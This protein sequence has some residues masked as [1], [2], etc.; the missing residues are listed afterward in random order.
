MGPSLARRLRR[1][2]DLSG[3]RRRIFAVSRFS[4]P[5]LAE[6]LAAA[7]IDVVRADLLERAQVDALPD[8]AHVFMLAGFK[9]G[10][11]DRPDRTWATNTV[12]PAHVAERYATSRLVVF[13]TGNVYPP[14]P[15][16]RGCT[17]AH[18]VG[19]IGEYAQSCLGR[20]RV[21]EHVS[22]ERG[23]PCVL[24]RLS[25]AVDLR[26]GVLVD[27]A[28][29]VHA[30]RPVDLGV[31]CVNAIWQ[32][33]AL[34]YAVRSLSLCASP[35]SPLNVTG[36]IVSVREAALAF[37]GYF[38]RPAQFL[39]GEGETALLSDASHC[40]SLFGPPAV[41]PSRLLRWV[42]HWVKT[43]GRL[44]GKPTAFEKTDGRY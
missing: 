12:V 39:G 3:K 7:G 30:G 13:S 6:S 4:S 41:S 8:A 18:A 31:P 22:R 21:I 2:A 29:R 36:P 42:A 25:Y 19:P 16:S 37:A 35:P 24:F 9:F 33:D 14:V 5:G 34:S 11:S 40:H 17:E 15:T 27:I 32:G 44:L 38:A 10:A 23:A 1:A 26:Y 20:E 43:G 28:E